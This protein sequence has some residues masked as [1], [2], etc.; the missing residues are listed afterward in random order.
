MN[1]T[2]QET[3]LQ[4]LEDARRILREYNAPRL[5]DAT[6]TVHRLIAVLERDE[7]VHA[8]NRMRKRRNLRLVE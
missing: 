1:N 8:I 7:L 6:L 3:V 4:A 2:D 5:G